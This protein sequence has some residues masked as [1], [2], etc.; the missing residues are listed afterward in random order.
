MNNK[1]KDRLNE[2]LRA[3]NLSQNKL[4]K[5]IGMSQTIVNNYCTG[6]REPTLDVLIMICKALDE[7]SDY[8]LGIK[9]Y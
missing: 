5:K 3:N 1:F 4:A 6:K 7:S 9:D 2:C 8:L